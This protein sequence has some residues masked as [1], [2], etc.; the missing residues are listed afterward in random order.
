MIELDIK[1]DNRERS[2]FARMAVF[3]DLRK[4]LTS[5]V[6]VN[7]H[8]QRVELEALLEVCFSFDKYGHL[9]N[10]CLSSLADRSGHG[11]VETSR[12]PSNSGTDSATKNDAL[13]MMGESFGLWMVVSAN[14]SAN[15]RDFGD[16]R[17]KF[18]IEIKRV[19]DL[20]SCLQWL[21]NL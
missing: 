6:L 3:V 12:S 7:G 10:L 13:P 19:P 15:R 14:L 8:L 4:P 9:K 2:Q 21:L 5:Q 11:R 17:H 1:I 16:K 20:K 18:R